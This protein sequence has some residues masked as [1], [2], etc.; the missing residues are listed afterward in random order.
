VRL[1]LF[2]ETYL[3]I[4]LLFSFFIVKFSLTIGNLFVEVHYWNSYKVEL[5]DSLC[6]DTKEHK[7]KQYIHQDLKHSMLLPNSVT[8]L[9]EPYVRMNRTDYVSKQCIN[10]LAL[11]N[12]I[13]Q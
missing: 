11:T 1:A 13:A 3:Y 7:I 8:K 12:N 6:H 5:P 9:Y 4:Y 2:S 10:N